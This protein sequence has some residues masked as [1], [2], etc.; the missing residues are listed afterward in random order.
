MTFQSKTSTSCILTDWVVT[1][2]WSGDLSM[3]ED[4]FERLIWE[5][6]THQWS[7]DLSIIWRGT[8]VSRLC[9]NSPMIW[10]PFNPYCYERALLLLSR[11]SP[12]IWWPFNT[13]WLCVL[14]RGL[15]VTHQ[16]SGDLSIEPAKF[17]QNDCCRN[18][19]MIWWPFN[20]FS[21][22]KYFFINVVTHQWSGDLSI[23]RWPCITAG[24]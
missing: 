3:Q 15:V 2:Q 9:R 10:W 19:P 24:S 11:N 16:W 22:F 1:H 18:S 7:G 13:Y 17:W 14:Y 8:T 20:S 21:C 23:Y 5:V 6:V 12:M 4:C